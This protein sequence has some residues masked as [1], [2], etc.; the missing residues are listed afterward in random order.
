MLSVVVVVVVLNSTVILVAGE[1]LVVDAVGRCC[2]CF[3]FC[4]C[5][6]WSF[7]LSVV[8]VVVVLADIVVL[9]VGEAL[10]V[11][12]VGRCFVFLFSWLLWVLLLV[13]VISDALRGYCMFMFVAFTLR[14]RV[15]IACE[16]CLVERKR[17]TLVGLLG[18]TLV[19]LP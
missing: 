9:V 3:C 10:V 15:G 5:C 16:I 19:K 7:M 13:V 2:C 4:C 17:L 1:L 6:W 14:L 12:D 18:S 8:H 11:D